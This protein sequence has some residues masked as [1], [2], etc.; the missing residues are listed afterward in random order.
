MIPLKRNIHK[1]SIKTESRL[2]VAYSWED[3]EKWR[4]ILM[5]RYRASFWNDEN[6]LEC[7]MMVAQLC[8][9]IENH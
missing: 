4:V 8:E 6:V 5:G 2:V 1:K 7:V 9:Y 3:W